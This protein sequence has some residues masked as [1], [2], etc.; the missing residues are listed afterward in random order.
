MSTEVTIRIE[1]DDEYADPNNSTG[2]TEEGFELF[3][4]LINRVGVLIEGPD[5]A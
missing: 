3:S 5:L 4:E 2:M 1:V